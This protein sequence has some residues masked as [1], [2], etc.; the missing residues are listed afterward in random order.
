MPGVGRRLTVVGVV[1]ALLLSVL[2]HVGGFGSGGLRHALDDPA[3]TTV[4]AAAPVGLARAAARVRSWSGS[5]PLS[6]LRFS[7]PGLLGLLL[8]L[9]LGPLLAV[10][11]FLARPD[12][13]L[14]SPLRR[15]PLAALRAP[16]APSFA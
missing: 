16:P 13:R 6:V 1:G 4:M 3:S 15:S 2:L 5:D 7:K 14:G 10:W 8:G 9:W 12:R 11:W